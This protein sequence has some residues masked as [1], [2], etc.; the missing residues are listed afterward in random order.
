M[1]TCRVC[2]AEQADSAFR[3]GHAQCKRCQYLKVT[4][5]RSRNR[6]K[7]RADARAWAARNPD[8][9]RAKRQA[10]YNNHSA[11]RR[12]K[13]KLYRVRKYQESKEQ[14]V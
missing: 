2:G 12:R 1:K 3:V 5:Y 8:K 9:A 11:E 7:I 6:A 4:I 13:A 14:T 10:D